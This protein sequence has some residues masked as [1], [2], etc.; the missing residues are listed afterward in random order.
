M[1]PEYTEE[2]NIEEIGISREKL[3]EIGIEFG[4]MDRVMYL[5]SFLVVSDLTPHLI[6]TH[7]FFQGEASYRTDPRKLLEVFGM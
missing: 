5:S 1:A 4:E 6:A 3:R 7:N 2:I